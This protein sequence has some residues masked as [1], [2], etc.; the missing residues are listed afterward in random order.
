MKKKRVTR[1]FQMIIDQKRIVLYLHQL[2]PLETSWIIIDEQNEIEDI[3]IRGDL[4]TLVPTIE[5]RFIHVIIPGEEV[6]L[7]QV[8]LPALSRERLL[9]AL[10]F[11]LE[12]KLIDDV[13]NLHFSIGDSVKQAITSV[14]IIKKEK[15]ETYLKTFN[16]FGLKPHTLIPVMLAL[17]WAKQQWSICCDDAISSVRLDALNG[18]TCDRSNLY[19]FLQ[20][21]W[22]DTVDKPH[23]IQIDNFSKNPV[24]LNHLP[25]TETLISEKHGLEK[26]AKSL[27]KNPYINLLQG[28]YRSQM[29]SVESKKIWKWAGVF[30]SIWFSLSLMSEIISFF[31]LH[32]ANA[33]SEEVIHLI[34]HQQF[35]AATS[36]VAP[37]ERMESA[38]KKASIAA[39]KNNFLTFLGMWGAAVSKTQG[40]QMMA[41]KYQ[42][43]NLNI[44]V[45]ARSFDALDLFI[46]D[47]SKQ[48]LKVKQ[49]NAAILGSE[50]KSTILI[51]KNDITTRLSSVDQTSKDYQ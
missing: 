35:P 5:E 29:K 20:S 33:Q 7:T 18:F 6:L 3:I 51:S 23:T 8:E 37:R 26:I 47:L 12:D 1:H 4:A 21:Q 39:N 46:H 9:Q 28:N 19:L 22:L 36:L 49:Q 45:T 34:Y 41:L 2:D 48:G 43:N 24:D 31:I 16:S 27:G 38:L 11:A 10:P 14:A 32:H 25:I 15:I 50:V 17:P 13:E 44:A 42:E 40:V 30:A